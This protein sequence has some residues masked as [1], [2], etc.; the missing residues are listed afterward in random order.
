MQPSNYF[1]DIE[2]A[3]FSP[4][5]MVPGWAPSADPGMSPPFTCCI[6]KY[7]NIYIVL[8][9]RLFA[10]SDAA[11]YRLGVN[12]Q[13]LPTN[14]AKSPVYCPF[15]RDGKMNFSS[16]YG[17]DPNYVGSSLKPTRFY[18]DVKGT[19]PK[20]HSLH[21]EHEKWVGEVVTFTSHITDDDFEQPAAL[22]EVIKKEPGHEQRFYNNVAGHLSKVKNDRLRMEIYRGFIYSFFVTI[23]KLTP[24]IDWFGRIHPELADGIRKATMAV[25]ES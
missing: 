13:M 2:Q 20:A 4:S 24:S 5:T 23:E 3:A 10:Y 19:G 17:G 22:W 16:N 6:N 11:R 15:Q 25:M 1:A 7:S 9:A 12:Y 18:Q 14:A 21:T 8:Q